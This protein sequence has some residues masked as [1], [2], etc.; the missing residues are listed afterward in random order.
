MS[1]LETSFA[2]LI[3]RIS[4]DL[5]CF[6]LTSHTYQIIQEYYIAGVQSDHQL[7][8]L[9]YILWLIHTPCYKLVHAL[10]L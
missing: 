9:G 5:R 3:L 10:L 2:Y 7:A 8:W 6:D 4:I 1:L